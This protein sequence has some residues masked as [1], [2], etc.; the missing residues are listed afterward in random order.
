MTVTGLAPVIPFK[1]YWNRPRPV[2]EPRIPEPAQLYN[3]TVLAFLLHTPGGESPLCVTCEQKWPCD[4][5]CLAFR[6]REGF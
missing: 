2:T 6:L 3:L 5:V 1:P 4:H